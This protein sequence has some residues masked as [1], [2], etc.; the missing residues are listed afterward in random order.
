MWN[1]RAGLRGTPAFVRTPMPMPGAAPWVQS[2]VF[3]VGALASRFPSI[4]K[5]GPGSAV[6]ATAAMAG[7]GASGSQVARAT[8]RHRIGK[9]SWLMA[10]LRQGWS[11]VFAVFGGHEGTPG[12]LSI[13]LNS[14]AGTKANGRADC[15]RPWS[16]APGALVPV[17]V[18]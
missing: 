4:S 15:A 3:A 16:G 13:P 12:R 11:A 2:D 18:V 7:A 1:V 5:P 6:G 9:N 14:W 8:A 17:S 10:A